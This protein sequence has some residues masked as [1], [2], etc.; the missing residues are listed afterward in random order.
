MLLNNLYLKT[1]LIFPLKS[2]KLA[3]MKRKYNRTLLYTEMELSSK[4]K[5]ITKL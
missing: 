1:L 4:S 5:L 2:T 3:L